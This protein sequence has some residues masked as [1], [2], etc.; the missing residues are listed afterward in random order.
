MSSS[1][2]PQLPTGPEEPAERAPT[3][4]KT[5]S[6]QKRIRKRYAAERRFRFFGLAAV[7]LSAAFLAFLLVT[8]I[9]QGWR[10]FLR[11]DVAV[12]MNFPALA[13]KVDRAQLKTPGADLALAGAELENAV[14]GAALRAF[15]PGGDD[16]ISESAWLRVREAIK[17][18]PTIL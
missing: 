18:D 2:I 5:H 8:M 17:A 11:T 7:V 14:G 16:Y 3:D 10:G 4:W 15:G 13:L 12:E 1:L 9:A 6:M